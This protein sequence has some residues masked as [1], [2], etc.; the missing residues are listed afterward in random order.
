MGLHQPVRPITCRFVY[1]VTCGVTDLDGAFEVSARTGPDLADCGDVVRKDA[2]VGHHVDRGF[3]GAASIVRGFDEF[4]DAQPGC[5][6]RRDRGVE[7]D[8]SP[9]ICPT[10]HAVEPRQGQAKGLE[11]GIQDPS[12]DAKYRGHIRLHPDI[13]PVFGS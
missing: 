5:C 8:V 7:G 13:G 10:V 11:D 12:D 9:T 2:E 6:C 4:R 1:L 3:G